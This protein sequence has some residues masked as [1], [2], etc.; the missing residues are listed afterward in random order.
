M[1]EC[2]RVWTLIMQISLQ[3]N[4]FVQEDLNEGG[5]AGLIL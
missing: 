2:T 1:V 3:L 4:K 5:D